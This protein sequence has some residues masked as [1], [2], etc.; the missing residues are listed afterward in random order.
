MQKSKNLRKTMRGKSK[1][2]LKSLQQG[3]KEVVLIKKGKLKSTP[4]K[5]F[6]DE[7]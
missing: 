5:D 3:L 6:L 7:L 4:L 2:V 1:L